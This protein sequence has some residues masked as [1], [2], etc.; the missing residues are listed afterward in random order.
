MDESL[1]RFDTVWAA[2][3]HPMAVFPATPDEML[4]LSG[5]QRAAFTDD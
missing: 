3:G 5:A 4:K 1:W 2:A